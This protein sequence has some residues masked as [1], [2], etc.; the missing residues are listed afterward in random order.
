MLRATRM[1]AAARA[2]RD[3]DLLVFNEQMKKKHEAESV[4][5]RGAPRQNARSLAFRAAPNGVVPIVF[6]I[7]VG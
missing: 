7:S 3:M 4:F 2:A 5:S 6:L 1:Q